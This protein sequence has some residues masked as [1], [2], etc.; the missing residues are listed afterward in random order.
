LLVTD[1]AAPFYGK[2]TSDTLCVSWNT[3]EDAN[4]PAGSPPGISHPPTATATSVIHLGDLLHDQEESL[5]RRLLDWLRDAAEK[6]TAPDSPLPFIY[7][8]LHGWWLLSITEKNYATTPQF[9]TLAKLMLLSE[10]ATSRGVTRLDY[11]GSDRSLKAVLRDYALANG[12]ATNARKVPLLRRVRR[13]TEPLQAVVHLARMFCT[14]CTNLARR[15]GGDSLP[16]RETAFGIVGYLIPAACDKRA[17]S[18]YWGTL[19]SHLSTHPP[20]D[21]SSHQSSH[22]LSQAAAPTPADARTLWLYHPS[23]ELSPADARTYCRTATTHVSLHHTIDDFVTISVWWRTLGTYRS[24]GRARRSLTLPTF[25][26]SGRPSIPTNE[27]FAD[28]MRDSLAG[29]RAVWVMAHCHVYDALVRSHPTTQ[30]MFLWEN[31]P[32]EHALT[33]AVRRNYGVH[34]AP[35]TGDR[36]T[37]DDQDTT[38]TTTRTIG[39]A[40]SVVRRRDHRY[41]EEWGL[42]PRQP[43]QRPVASVYAVNGP[44]A[45][46]NLRDIALPGAPVVEVE[47]LRY[48]SLVTATHREPARLLVLGDISED[49]SRR[50]LEVTSQALAAHARPVVEPWFKP[51]PGSPSHAEIARAHGFAVTDEHLS[52]LAPSLALAVVGVAGAASVDLTLLGVPTATVLDA[53][54][55]NLSPLV[56]VAGACFVRSVG[57]LRNFI[58]SPQLR[59][60]AE[61]GLMHRAEPPIRWLHLLESLS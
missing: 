56:G 10:L 60:L 5:Q 36:D 25:Q 23:D 47:A 41:F 32:F 45:H 43:H 28:Q 9:T 52:V 18:P 38:G 11:D 54:S 48:S 17:Q 29:S 21:S 37:T 59:G 26:S 3:F 13:R 40:H 22:Q 39:Y 31:K 51:H 44:L 50:L 34:K 7:P 53:R 24:F 19:P 16:G 57:E 27:L 35:G 42:S 6:N 58:A 15:A 8:N 14:A 2:A 33:S 55:M 1:A 4:S 49:E 30:W 61:S 46:R 12:W 20:S